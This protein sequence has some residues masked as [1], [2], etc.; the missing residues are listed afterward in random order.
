MLQP[1]NRCQIGCIL[2]FFLLAWAFPSLAQNP[3]VL[4]ARATLEK[5]TLSPGDKSALNVVLTIAKPY[6]VN[7][8]PASEAYL[9]ATT[10]T[11]KAGQG[12]TGGKPL[13]PKAETKKFAFFSKPLKVYEGTVTVEVPLSVADNATPGTRQVSGIV[14]YQACNDKQC[15]L[16]AQAKFRT[17]LRVAAGSARSDKAASSDENPPALLSAAAAPEDI[18]SVAIALRRKYDVKGFPAIVFLD[19]QGKERADLRAGEELT[20][21]AMIQKLQALKSGAAGEVSASSATGLLRRLESAPLWLQLALVFVGGLLL[22]LTPCVYPI[23]PITVG[24]FGAQSEGRVSRTF[25]LACL[26]VLGLALVYSILGLTAALTGSLFGSLF[27]NPFVLGGVAL[28]FFVLALSML[29]MFTIQ[30]PQFLLARSGAKKGALGALG[31]GALLGIVAAPCVGPV[32]AALLTYV[33]ANRNPALG[34]ILFFVLSLGLGLP[35]LLLGAFSGALKSLPRSGL[36]LERSKKIFAVPILL[37]AFYYGYLALKPQL[38]APPPAPTTAM[39]GAPRNP[40]DAWQ[41]ATLTALEEARRSN[42]PVVMDFRAD[43]C[44]PCLHLEETVFSKPDVLRT[45]EGVTLLKVDFSFSE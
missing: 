36:W 33:G 8:N 20:R 37:A 30:P 42:R 25:G 10:V 1:R 4:T 11:I 2:T 7:A 16:P 12:V 22:N 39:K 32:V 9:I 14:K 17:T 40:K 15:L 35:Y 6:H 27:Q 38:T 3:N 13:Y 44:L 21:P 43:W 45:A 23:I 41:P 5:N 26:Y 18:K 19:G 24:Y 29:G 28:V 34:F 31:M